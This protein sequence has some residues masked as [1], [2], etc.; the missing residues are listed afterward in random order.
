MP[1]P[2]LG[3]HHITGAVTNPQRDYDFYTGV[4]GLR[5]VKQTINHDSP[6]MWHFF[7]ADYEGNA[8][9]VMTNIIFDGIPLPRCTPGRGSISE[10][11]YSIP[12]GSRDFW[13]SRLTDAGYTC[14]ERPDRFGEAVL[15][16]EDPEGLPSEMIECDDER[17]PPA[18]DGFT[19]ANVV[20]GF[21]GLTLV[22]RLPELTEQFF[23]KIMGFEVADKDENRT[24]LAISGGGP[25]KWVDLIDQPEGPWAS[26]GI[27]AIHHV[28]F[29]VP[30]LDVMKYFWGKM[31][32]A[33]LIVTDLRDRKW[34]H[35][36]YLTEP[37]G[38]N[39]E[40]SN[41]DPGF[42]V[43]EKLEELGTS[44]QLPKQWADIREEI[45]GKLPAMK[46]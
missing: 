43:D 28:S 14:E 32:G 12:K 31:S 24:R 20:R 30:D 4:L 1:A 22:S 13:K 41:V 42:T 25:G 9:T 19:D 36:A 37:G 21:H 11:S 40:L 7:Y 45:E 8:G 29:T 27:G 44:L 26:F 23:T 18:P 46:F 34:F 39:V 5:L 3:I 10:L 33:G 38:I 16:F 35:S 17:K 15:Y 6:N 2:V